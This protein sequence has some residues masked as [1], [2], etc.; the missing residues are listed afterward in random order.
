MKIS[1]F[2]EN[3]KDILFIRGVISEFNSDVKEIFDNYSIADTF[4]YI[5]HSVP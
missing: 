4:D 2:N 1:K 3:K 5:A